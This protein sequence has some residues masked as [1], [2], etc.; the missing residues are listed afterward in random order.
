MLANVLTRVYFLTGI[1]PQD[2]NKLLFIN[3]PVLVDVRLVEQFGDVLVRD[4][5]TC[6]VIY[7]AIMRGEIEKYL[8][9]PIF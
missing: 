4:S 3:L 6:I 1:F 9:L 7:I 5:S 2:L 8:I